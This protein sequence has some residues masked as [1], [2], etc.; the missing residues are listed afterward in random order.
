LL[1]NLTVDHR[2][3]LVFA[4]LII[5][6]STL[7]GLGATAG[8]LKNGWMDALRTHG[9]RKTSISTSRKL[10]KFAAIQVAMATILTIGATALYRSLE[11]TTAIDP[12]FDSKH[13]LTMEIDL[14]PLRYDTG[15]ARLRFIEAVL[16][17]IR[18]APGIQAA[19]VAS[20]LPFGGLHGNGRFAIAGSDD[21]GW[22]GPPAERNIA[23]P[24]FFKAM[25][26]PILAGRDFTESD[27]AEQAIIV[28]AALANAYLEAK[29][30]IGSYLKLEGLP[31]EFRVIGVAGNVKRVRLDEPPLFY[32]YFPYPKFPMATVFLAVH[33]KDAP[34]LSV[35]SIK[36]AIQS[37]DSM[38]PVSNIASME[39]RILDSLSGPRFNA[40]FVGACAGLAL[41]LALV[42][43]YSTVSY[44]VATRTHEIGIRMAMGAEG[45]HLLV[46]LLKRM[47][48]Y[49][50]GGMVVGVICVLLLR[51]LLLHGWTVVAAPIDS[52]LL[53]L[54]CFGIFFTATIAALL[55]A[56]RAAHLQPSQALRT[57]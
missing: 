17:R 21:K 15:E 39:D 18:A 54:S 6:S 46:L 27:G 24:G 56:R 11:K 14:V 38:Q 40:G 30:P 57:E 10:Q 25:G 45:R 19:G 48:V 20:F 22:S 13:V 3:L 1:Q 9:F 35:S 34:L 8:A 42:A 31:G 26:I 43:V 50:T 37:V 52:A 51:V 44:I 29:N 4:F 28:S 33:T 32:V 55:P 36:A 23:S 7:A 12:G 2:I 47:L 41:V 5:G 49:I 53:C 16:D